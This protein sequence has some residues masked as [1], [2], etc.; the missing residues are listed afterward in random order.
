MML[1]S[2]ATALALLCALPDMVAAVALAA[3]QQT[4]AQLPPPWITV[5][6]AGSARTVTPQLTVTGGA[7]STI[8]PPPD[9]LTRVQTWRMSTHGAAITTTTRAPIATATPSGS[10][11]SPGGGVMLKCQHYVGI[12]APFC[13]P[14]RGSLLNPGTT[15]YLTWD[16]DFFGSDPDQGIEVQVSYD[17][18]LGFV[19][20]KTRAS[21][22]FY[23]WSVPADFLEQRGRTAMNVTWSINFGNPDGSNS[24]IHDEGPTVTVTRDQMLVGDGLPK[25]AGAGGSL[26][27]V[28]IVVPVV[29]VALLVL[30][31]GGF[32]LWSWRR[33]GV[34][35]GAAAIGALKRRST[36]SGG[37]YGERRSR[38]ERAAG[39]Q[40][41]DPAGPR[42]AG[43]GDQLPDD[44]FP[45]IQ[46]TDRD[47]WSP[48]SPSS[49]RNVFQEEIR[50]Q[51]TGRR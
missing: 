21:V 40:Q 25:G 29:V 46:L 35:P 49:G 1:F 24:T 36:T 15:Y 5:D 10:A 26:A 37:G 34:V 41:Q 13:A 38:S 43:P 48:T 28:V 47:S 31:L 44:K 2:R 42:P 14:Y 11:G 32:C 22:G 17:G 7:T 51:E 39:Q 4:A 33:K 19:T 18:A 3:R 20:N 12:D 23:A 6:A 30:G 8:S 9:E 27:A 50:R 45:G 16:V